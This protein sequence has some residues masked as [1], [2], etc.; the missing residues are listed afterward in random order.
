M[1]SSSSDHI[2]TRKSNFLI[3]LIKMTYLDMQDNYGGKWERRRNLNFTNLQKKNHFK[4]LSLYIKENVLVIIARAEMG[5]V[6]QDKA[7]RM[8]IQNTDL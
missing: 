6:K 3:G 5:T 7:S 1:L 4:V 2:L 8:L